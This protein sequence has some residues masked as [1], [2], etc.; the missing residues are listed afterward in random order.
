MPED[1]STISE[2]SAACS[3][4]GALPKNGWAAGFAV[5]VEGFGG[6]FSAV[7]FMGVRQMGVTHPQLHSTHS[8]SVIHGSLIMEMPQG[9]WSKRISTVRLST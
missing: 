9:S 5:V 3:P 1:T 6:A 7:A 4:T 8:M 2:L